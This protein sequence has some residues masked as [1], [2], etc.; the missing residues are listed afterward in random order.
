LD[1]NGLEVNDFVVTSGNDGSWE[2]RGLGKGTYRVLWTPN[3][4]PELTVKTSPRLQNVSLDANT[5]VR[6]VVQSFELDG[7][8]S[9]TGIDFGIQAKPAVG[10][11]GTGT[12]TSGSARWSLIII[13]VLAT[14]L[15]VAMAVGV[16]K[17]SV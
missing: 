17:R 5:T 6:A 8:Q 16:L 14:G 7:E 15:V 11:P 9:V 1:E 4:P 3:L 2:V 10:L 12:G 13:G